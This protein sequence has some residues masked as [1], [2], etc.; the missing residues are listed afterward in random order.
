MARKLRGTIQD[1][2]YDNDDWR[3][4][5]WREDLML[6]G[7]SVQRPDLGVQLIKQDETWMVM[8]NQGHYSPHML[9]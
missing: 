1:A 9:N 3:V 7:E 5:S 2:V 4:I 6:R 8:D